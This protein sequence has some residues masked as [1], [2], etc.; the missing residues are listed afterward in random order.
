MNPVIVYLKLIQFI[1]EIVCLISKPG[2]L[3]ITI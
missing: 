2:S 1:T 3:E